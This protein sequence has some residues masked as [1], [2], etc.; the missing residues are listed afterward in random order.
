MKKV[1]E[2]TELK[3]ITSIS[4]SVREDAD[5]DCVFSPEKTAIRFEDDADQYWEV[6]VFFIG[7]TDMMNE[8]NH[9]VSGKVLNCIFHSLGLLKDKW[10]GVNCTL[11]E[12]V[13][14]CR[15]ELPKKNAEENRYFLQKEYVF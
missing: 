3:I 10:I 1:K 8:Y 7:W 14:Q 9:Y 6:C 13:N 2:F 11:N 15:K 4:W 5:G 12:A